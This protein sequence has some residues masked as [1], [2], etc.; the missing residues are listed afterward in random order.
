MKDSLT[1]DFTTEAVEQADEILASVEGAVRALHG[2]VEGHDLE[3]ADLDV[4][5]VPATITDTT[6]E[7]LDASHR[8]S[9]LCGLTC[10]R[11]EL[12]KMSNNL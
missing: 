12:A 9:A 5:R 8:A 4:G 1:T 6:V 2:L 10:K 3:V 7:E 11:N